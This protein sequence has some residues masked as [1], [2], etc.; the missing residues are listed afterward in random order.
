MVAKDSESE[1]DFPDDDESSDEDEEWGEGPTKLKP[2]QKK[3]QEEAKKKKKKVS[4]L[5]A[6]DDKS[7]DDELM[8]DAKKKAP[9]IIKPAELED[10]LLVTL[11]RNRIGKWCKEPYFEEAV[12]NFFVKL[13]VGENEEGTRCYRLC[14]IVSVEKS[15]QPYSLPTKPGRKKEKPVV[16]DKMLKLD[17][18]GSRKVFPIRLISDNKVNQGDVN[19]YETAMKANRKQEELLGKR[20]AKKMRKKRDDLIENFTYTNEDIERKLKEKKMKGVS[21]T[22]LG[23]EQTRA[24]NAVEA[25][26][27]ALQDA[28]SRLEEAR[29][30]AEATDAKEEVEIAE[31]NLRI[32]LDQEKLIL[33][34]VKSRREKNKKRAKNWVDVNERANKLNRMAD[35]GLNKPKGVDADKSPSGEVAY[36]PYARRNVKPK[37]LWQVGQGDEKK[38]NDENKEPTETKGET[39]T[40]APPP[41]VQEQHGKKAALNQSHQFAIDE[42]S[43]VQKSFLDGIGGIGAKKKP[44]KRVRKGMSLAEYQ[45]RKAAGTL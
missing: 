32:K 36:N 2:W 18:A 45:E 1:S 12:T 22:N 14:R 10:F 7:D 29:D 11:S 5:D 21:S 30:G 37:I 3:A 8:E 42:E 38:E 15:E 23:L 9:K 35:V 39:N 41:L 44:K 40:Q 43:L 19:K 17:F 28:K 20:E 4:Q 13:F 16:T 6:L 33:E 34:K 31:E 25:A 24:A 26:R 27:G